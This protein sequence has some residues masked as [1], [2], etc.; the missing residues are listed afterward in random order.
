[1]NQGFKIVNLFSTIVDLLILN[2]LFVLTSLP[3]ITI[4]ASLTALYSVTLKMVKN[5]ESYIAK[6][7][8]RAFKR[9]FV[10]STK[11]FVFIAV[12]SA[13]MIINILLAFN[14]TKL[15]FM[16]IQI[17]STVF[18]CI[19]YIYSIYFFPVLARFDF[20]LKQVFM[21]ISHMIINH[22]GLFLFII[23]LNIPVIFLGLYSV[24]TAAFLLIFLLI[25]GTSLLTYIHSF[26]FR[27]IFENYEQ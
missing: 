27:R 19:I 18:L 9:N 11:T 6:S 15:Y 12:F 20:T 16:F 2:I 21:H 8:F 7:Y 14:Q 26:I 24:N 10:L 22:I 17:A 23:C 3:I 4:G 5:E 13:L 25:I 1:M